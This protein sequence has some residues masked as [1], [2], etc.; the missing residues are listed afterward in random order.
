MSGIC[1]IYRQNGHGMKLIAEIRGGRVTGREA[2]RV[3]ELLKPYGFPRMSVDAM[4]DQLLLG[5]PQLAV[6]MI[7]EKKD[8]RK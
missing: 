1:R 2:A 8:F 4:V 5:D 3:R 6:A 7:A